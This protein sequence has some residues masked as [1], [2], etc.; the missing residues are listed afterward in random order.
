MLGWWGMS[1]IAAGALAAAFLPAAII[2]GG[3]WVNKLWDLSP[4]WAIC[5]IIGIATGIRGC[6]FQRKATKLQRTTAFVGTIFS[7]LTFMVLTI[8]ATIMSG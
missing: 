2:D 7:L 3:D 5:C 4:L 6:Q 8:I 1:S